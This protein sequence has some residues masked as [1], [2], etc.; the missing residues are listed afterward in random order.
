MK[1]QR[2]SNRFDIVYQSYMQTG[3]AIFFRQ[4]HAELFYPE[5]KGYTLE[6]IYQNKDKFKNFH[7]RCT[8]QSNRILNAPLFKT[9]QVNLLDSQNHTTIDAELYLMFQ[10]WDKTQQIKSYNISLE[11]LQLVKTTN[12]DDDYFYSIINRLKDNDEELWREYSG[13]YYCDQAKIYN[14]C[15]CIAIIPLSEQY[16]RISGYKR[17]V[18]GIDFED[19]TKHYFSKSMHDV[20]FV[21]FL[22]ELLNCKHTP[23]EKGKSKKLDNVKRTDHIINNSVRHITINLSKE[24]IRRRT[25]ALNKNTEHFSLDKKNLILSPSFVGGYVR[26]QHYGKKNAEIK[27]IWVD[28]FIRNQWKVKATYTRVISKKI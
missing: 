12:I 18:I 11:T 23:L 21:I 7:E 20:A 24:Y 1:K 16:Q 8:D 13:I 10:Q 15:N 27:S 6:E 9:K 25:Q 14:S 5:L 19:I 17:S 22:H 3:Q 26:N 4:D 2:M 28:G